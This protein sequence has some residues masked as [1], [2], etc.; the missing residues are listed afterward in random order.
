MCWEILRVELI[1]RLRH[2]SSGGAVHD[3][4]F[5]VMGICRREEAACEWQKIAKYYNYCV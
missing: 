5:V 4:G 1:V 3:H 2:E